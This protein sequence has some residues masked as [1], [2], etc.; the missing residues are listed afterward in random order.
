M[1]VGIDIGS[2]VKCFRLWQIDP[3]L[4]RANPICD[5]LLQV[6]A[7]TGLKLMLHH[8]GFS[9]PS[10]TNQSAQYDVW[11]GVGCVGWL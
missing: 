5:G 4:I 6:E 8:L 11:R 3:T 1:V 7:R 2:S 9:E 10:L